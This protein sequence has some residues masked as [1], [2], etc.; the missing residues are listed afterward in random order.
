[1]A[2]AGYWSA[3]AG[4][5]DDVNGVHLSHC[6]DYLR[7]AIMC[8]GDATLEWWQAP[9]NNLGSTGWGYQHQ[10]KDYGALYA[11]ADRHRA[12]DKKVIHGDQGGIHE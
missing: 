1:M 6:W 10:C 3:L 2:R 12:T 5:I 9:P 7:Q 11:Y 4:N 8:A